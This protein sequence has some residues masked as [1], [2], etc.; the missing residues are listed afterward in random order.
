MAQSKVAGDAGIADFV[1]PPLSEILIDLFSDNH[2]VLR[3]QPINGLD[4]L[5]SSARLAAWQT[6]A[7][8]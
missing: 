2:A 1:R 6:T 7:S 4:L 8:V 3:R 5:F